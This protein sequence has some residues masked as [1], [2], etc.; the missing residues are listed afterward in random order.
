M[1]RYHQSGWPPDNEEKIKLIVKTKK[2][3]TGEEKSEIKVYGT[4][5]RTETEA[6]G[7]RE[8]GEKRTQVRMGQMMAFKKHEKLCS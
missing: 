6:R 2:R 4:D 3:E 5:E 8:G 7:N 1:K